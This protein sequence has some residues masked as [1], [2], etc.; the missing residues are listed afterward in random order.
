MELLRSPMGKGSLAEL[1]IRLIQ[2]RSET[3]M[4][5]QEQECFIERCEV[6]PHQMHSVNVVRDTM[7]SSLLEGMDVVMI[8]GAGEFS[9]YKDYPWMDALLDLVVE[10]TDRN[11]P[12]FG[13]CWGH[14]IIARALGGTVIHDK[15]TAEMGCGSIELTEAGVSDELFCDYPTEFLANM[16]HHDRVSI[17]PAGAI[18]LARS[19]SQGNQ[20]FR[21][22]GKPVYGTQFHSELD[23][24]RERE[25][26]ISYR[27]FYID[28]V[29]DENDFW[30]IVDS[31]QETT[32]VDGLLNAFLLKFCIGQ[33]TSA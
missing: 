27:R 18:E 13:S 30:K 20:A 3:D 23:A 16:G 9:A 15:S 25:R 33:E 32:E 7:S 10:C 14:Q 22:A 29:P 21:L 31:L 26:L 6:E 19:A 5:L 4:E 28:T 24:S 8:G 11:I 17:L 2:A 1:N 12:L